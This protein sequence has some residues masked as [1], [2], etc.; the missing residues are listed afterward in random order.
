VTRREEKEARYKRVAAMNAR[1]AITA[2]KRQKIF[3]AE[4]KKAGHDGKKNAPRKCFFCLGT[5]AHTIT[6]GPNA[7]GTPIEVLVVCNKCKNSN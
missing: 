5:T 2:S 4:C 3:L 6:Y 1:H 7:V